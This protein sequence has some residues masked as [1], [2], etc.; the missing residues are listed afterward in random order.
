MRIAMKRRQF[1]AAA[2]VLPF[3]SN[4]SFAQG[5]TPKYADMH[6]HLGFKLELGLR[7]QMSGS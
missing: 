2:G 6:A 5:K 4:F 1:I 7:A 3:L